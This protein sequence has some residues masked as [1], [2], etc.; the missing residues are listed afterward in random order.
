MGKL[1]LQKETALIGELKTLGQLLDKSQN[2]IVIILSDLLEYSEDANAYKLIKQKNGRLP[3][4]QPGYLL[5]VE[6]V[7]LGGGYGVKNSSQNYRLEMI[8]GE[9]FNEANVKK[10]HYLSYY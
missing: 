5:N 3:C 9:Y 8:W 2:N 6:I 4:P 10:F 1:E 7:A